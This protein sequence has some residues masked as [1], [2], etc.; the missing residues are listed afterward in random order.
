MSKMKAAVIYGEK[1][2]RIEEVDVKNV[3]NGQVKVKVGWAGICGSDL[4]AFNHG[5]ALAYD[6]HP[7][8][9]D[10]T[11]LVLGHEFS[12]TVEEIGNGVTSVAVGDKVAIE[13]MLYCGECEPCCT[14]KYNLR[15]VSN[16][17]FYGLAGDGGFAEYFV[18]E[19]KYFHK[20]P[21]NVSLEEGA[22]VEPTAVAFH[23]VGLSGLKAG[24]TAAIYGAGP[25][26]L[27]TLLCAQAYGA[28]ETFVIDL[29]QE[30][31]DKAK[32]LGATHVINA[33]DADAVKKIMEVTENRGVD[34]AFEVAG[35]NPTFNSAVHSIKRAGVV[36]VIAGFG[37]EVSFNPNDLLSIE[38]QIKFSLAYAHDYKPVIKAIAEGNLDVLKVVTNRISLDDVVKDGIELLNTDKSQAKVLISPN[39][40]A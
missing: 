19:E 33:G 34:V 9:K 29:S 2:L 35:A 31:L 6:E 22:L 25:I 11:P 30:R 39:G 27:L 32:E 13:P 16:V 15:E 12:G 23:A 28:A 24:Q 17:G 3:E 40:E 18:A 1:D 37:G 21:E 10:K 20:L 5:L 4:H 38:G 36:Q 7:L 8:T 26:G 14:G